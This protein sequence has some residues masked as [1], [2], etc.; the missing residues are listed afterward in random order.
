MTR[1]LL[2][3]HGEVDRDPE[4]VWG[5]SD[6]VPLNSVGVSQALRVGDYFRDHGITPDV[7]YSSGAVRATQ[8][9]CRAMS[10]AGLILPLIIDRRFHE[11]SQGRFEGKRRDAVYPDD[12]LDEI[13][14]KQM[15][16]RLPG[17]ESANDV[18]A[19]MLD[20][21]REA[22]IAWPDQTVLVG[23]HGLATRCLVGTTQGWSHAEITRPR[24]E[25]DTPNCSLTTLDVNPVSGVEVVAFAENILAT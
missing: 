23:T 7:V 16:F 18:S 10:R 25:T 15:D 9:V 19:R 4:R 21:V 20:A 8:T 6:S 5:Q 11:M 24:A 3:R 13:Q 1:I 2:L 12:V 17:S 22:G 14:Q